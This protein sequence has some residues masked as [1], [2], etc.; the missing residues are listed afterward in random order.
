V[1]ERMIDDLSP[2]RQSTPPEAPTHAPSASPK[3]GDA[4]KTNGIASEFET[5]AKV[6]A[7][8]VLGLYVIGLLA[9]NGYLFTLRVSDFSLIRP[10]FVY[11]GAILCTIAAISYFLPL[12]AIREI[13][14]RWNRDDHNSS[15]LRHR[16][17]PLGIDF[18]WFF[19][20]PF[21]FLA[22]FLSSSLNE[23]TPKGIPFRALL[24]AIGLSVG[25]FMY[26]DL[27]R[28]TFS[29]VK[30]RQNEKTLSITYLTYSVFAVLYVGA[31]Y[32]AL[33]VGT[34]Y[35]RIPEQFGGGQP[36]MVVL[37]FAKDAPLGLQNLGITS[38][39]PGGLSAPVRL[40]YEGSD[41]YVL[42]LSNGNIVKLDKKLVSATVVNSP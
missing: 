32:G 26:G 39:S 12:H 1:A 21:I 34:I 5:W 10:R 13:R 41:N 23:Q 16:L 29:K 9:I 28:R 25:G 15:R 17:I 40:V 14:S 33:L 6:A 24:I 3:A 35:N 38:A 37:L 8:F 20:P 30:R 18:V 4:T 7:A 22:L 42:R 27:I 2:A 11:A 31:F 36:K 19:F